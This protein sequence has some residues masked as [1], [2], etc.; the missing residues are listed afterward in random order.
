MSIRAQRQFLFLLS[1]G[2]LAATV[3][4]VWYGLQKPTV[5]P[6]AAPAAGAIGAETPDGSS[7]PDS[8]K[9]LLTAT[10]TKLRR[11]LYDPVV[12][13]V[14]PKVVRV[15]K[16]QK[17]EIPKPPPP[18]I[19][20]TLLGTVVEGGRSIAIVADA[21]GSIDQK[22]IGETLQL[23]PDGLV[24]EDIQTGEVIV[25]HDGKR[26]TFSVQT[27]SDPG[28]AKDDSKKDRNRNKQRR[29]DR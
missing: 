22:Q 2:F 3:G 27:Q 11:P 8:V 26:L 7:D 20:L 1:A 12:K 9:Q 23:K 4:A 17:R 5:E 25:S 16:P 6:L 18:K 21:S 29:R 15:A 28:T 14:A 10:D 19:E 13:P 24:L